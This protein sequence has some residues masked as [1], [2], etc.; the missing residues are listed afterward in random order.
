MIINCLLRDTQQ[1]AQLYQRQMDW[2]I[3][4]TVF[5]FLSVM[6]HRC[7]ST[8]NDVEVEIDTTT[9][10]VTYLISKCQC[11]SRAVDDNMFELM[12]IE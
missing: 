11:I 6:L 7:K 9:V 3:E 10:R 12:V 2:A 4:A 5:E 8:W 1:S